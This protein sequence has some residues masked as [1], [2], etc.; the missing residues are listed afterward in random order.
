M[1]V[2]HLLLELSTESQLLVLLHCVKG[3]ISGRRYD[4][5]NRFSYLGT[6]GKENRSILKIIVLA[7]W[8]LISECNTF[9]R[10]CVK[11][12]YTFRNY[13]KNESYCFDFW[14]FCDN[15]F[16]NWIGLENWENV[17]ENHIFWCSNQLA[18]KRTLNHLVKLVSRL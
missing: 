15:F 12:N 13:M 9:P 8:K 17:L 18:C 16:R 2:W 7:S 6:R 11:N 5:R 3:K 10:Y 4:N 14:F 1:C